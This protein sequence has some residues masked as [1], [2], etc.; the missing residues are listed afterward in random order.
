MPISNFKQN[1][2]IMFRAL[3]SHSFVLII[4]KSALIVFIL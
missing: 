3:L 2:T 4:L 1:L